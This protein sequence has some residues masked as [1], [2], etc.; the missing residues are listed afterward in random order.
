MKKHQSVITYIL[1]LLMLLVLLKM[2]RVINIRNIE[3]LGYVL[4]FF[5]LSYVF[6]SFGQNKPGLLFTATVIFLSGMILF[7]TSN[8]E[9]IQ[10]SRLILPAFLM[11]IGIGFLMVYIDGGMRVPILVFSLSFII[12][13]IIVTVIRGNFA[14]HTFFTSIS[15]MAEKYWPVLLIFAGVILLF[16]KEDGNT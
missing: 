16:R 5:G 8:F 6:N 12:A 15:G 7:I 2:T 3:L 13:G 4:I 9:I 14:M 10:P 11:I 1:I